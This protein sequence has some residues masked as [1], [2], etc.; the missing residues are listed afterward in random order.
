MFKILSHIYS[1]ITSV[2]NWLFDKQ[3]LKSENFECPVISIGNISTGGTGKTPHTEFLIRQLKNKYKLGVLSRG[4]KRKS[5]GF[6]FVKK[7]TGVFDAGDEPWQI[8]HKFPSVTIAVDAKRVRGVKQLLNTGVNCIVLDDA[9]QHRYIKPKL[10]ILLVDYNRPYYN[11]KLLPLGALREKPQQAL[12]RA[13]MVIITKC[14]G[15]ITEKEKEAI[16]NKIQ[17]P[18]EIFF[19]AIKYKEHIQ[20]IFEK[21]FR[22]I[23][24]DDNILLITGIANSK[25]LLD[26]LYTKCPNVHH[27]AFKDHYFYDKNDID[28]ITQQFEVIH[29]KNKVAYILTTEKD[30][31]RIQALETLMP[32]IK[33][34]F[35]FIEIEVVFLGNSPDFLSYI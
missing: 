23:K 7:N 10:S 1:F 16:A 11:D 25:P 2:R 29:S 6:L 27:I 18:K 24:T 14:P 15:T 32:G 3:F 19:S 34:Y 12:E 4:Y 8:K 31:A 33:K 17:F 22:E 26:Y 9:H 13:D 35:Y 5:K 21:N 20:H 30:M 28:I